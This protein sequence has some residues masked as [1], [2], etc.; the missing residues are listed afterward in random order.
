MSFELIETVT[1]GAGGASSIEFTSIPQDGVDLVLMTSTRDT[2]T[3][4]VQYANYVQFN[5]DTGSNYQNVQLGGTGSSVFSSAP[6]G[7]NRFISGS[8]TS[9][10]VTANTFSNNS[11]CIS[12]YTSSAAKSGSTDAV[13]ENNATDARTAILALSYS[14]TS[15]ITSLKIFTFGTSFAEHSTASLY[16]IY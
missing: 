11:L 13:T 12:N 2:A 15:A 5:N 8:S 1:V 3:G 16:K 4:G 14:G 9:A 6:S 7:T 10:S